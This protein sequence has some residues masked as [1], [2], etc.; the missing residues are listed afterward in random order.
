MRVC[1]MHNFQR[2]YLYKSLNMVTGEGGEGG[3]VLYSLFSLY[4]S[5]ENL[6]YIFQ[7]NKFIGW[8]V[9]LSLLA[10]ASLFSVCHVMNLFKIHV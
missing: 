2:I 6:S 5:P 10:A 7:F 3:A 1:D 9:Q 4:T 8:K